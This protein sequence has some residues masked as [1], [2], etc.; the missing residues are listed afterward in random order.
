MLV[1]ID[2][3]EKSFVHRP[4]MSE[5]SSQ[6]FFMRRYTTLR[7]LCKRRLILQEQ[8][9]STPKSVYTLQPTFSMVF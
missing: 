8:K 9:V 7:E 2:L 5:V 4:K 1:V 6:N 3:F